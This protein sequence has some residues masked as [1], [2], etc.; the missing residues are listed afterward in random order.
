MTIFHLSKKGYGSLVEL[1]SLDSPKLLNLI[2]Y[3][4]IMLDIEKYQIEGA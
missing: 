3:E 4:N 2:E 1:E